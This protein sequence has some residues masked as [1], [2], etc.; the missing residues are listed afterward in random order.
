MKCCSSVAA[1]LLGLFRKVA[2]FDAQEQRDREE[3]AEKVALAREKQLA[4]FDRQNYSATP[5]ADAENRRRL[6]QQ[7]AENFHGANSVKT[8]A[9]EEEAVRTM[10]AYWL[11][12]ATPDAERKLEAPSTDT[13]CPEGAEKLR[14]KDLFP[15]IFTEL[16]GASGVQSAVGPFLPSWVGKLLGRMNP[17][18]WVG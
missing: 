15:I 1:P 7:E 8:T 13:L 17:P 10:R 3:A 11:P 6:E 16:P 5:A 9:F 18:S 14:L 2:A 12:S 4:D